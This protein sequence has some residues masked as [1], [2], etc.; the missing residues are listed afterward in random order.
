MV[1][2]VVLVISLVMADVGDGVVEHLHDG[3]PI[4]PTQNLYIYDG[5]GESDDDDDD[6]DCGGGGGGDGVV[7]HLPNGQA[8]QIGISTHLW[9]KECSPPYFVSMLCFNAFHVSSYKCGSNAPKPPTENGWSLAWS[10]I[11]AT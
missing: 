9:P 11:I 5:D 1:V 2:V 8:A 3:Q 6:D 10:T 4:C 7:E